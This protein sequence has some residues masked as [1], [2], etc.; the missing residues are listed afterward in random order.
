MSAPLASSSLDGNMS[1][2]IF[3]PSNGAHERTLLILGAARSM[4]S[5]LAGALHHGGIYFGSNIHPVYECQRLG[6]A[7]ERMDQTAFS[8]TLRRRN[9][10]PL[11][12]WKRPSIIENGIG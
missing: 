2:V 6:Q 7:M 3:T 11:W 9:E 4:T 12:G 8:E 5:L 1:H 10:L